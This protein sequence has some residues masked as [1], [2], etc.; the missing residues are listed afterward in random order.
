MG[1]RFAQGPVVSPVSES[2]DSYVSCYHPSCSPSHFCVWSLSPISF[3]GQTPHFPAKVSW[4]NEPSYL[5]LTHLGSV[6]E[7]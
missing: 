3:I 1:L 2:C 5:S 7:G 6:G 4:F